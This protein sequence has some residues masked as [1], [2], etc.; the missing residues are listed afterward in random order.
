MR[1]AFWFQLIVESHIDFHH[2]HIWNK[3][4]VDQTKKSIK[5]RQRRKIAQ[6]LAFIHRVVVIEYRWTNENFCK[7]HSI[8]RSQS[9]RCSCV[10]SEIRVEIE[11]ALKSKVRRRRVDNATQAKSLIDDAHRT[12]VT[13]VSQNDERKKKIIAQKKNWVSLNVQIF[14]Q[15]VVE[16]LTFNRLSEE[17]KSQIKKNI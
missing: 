9:N 8:E 3:F 13:K 7:F 12:V 14:H 5:T 16:I 10:V 11:I 6:Q 15:L 4:C 17:S 1:N 2:I